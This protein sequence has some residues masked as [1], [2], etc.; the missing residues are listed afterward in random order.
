[1][2]ATFELCNSYVFEKN[3]GE[4]GK[5]AD[6]STR[7]EEMVV[8]LPVTLKTHCG[9]VR[10]VMTAAAGPKSRYSDGGVTSTN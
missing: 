9:D 1:M 6:I 5:D 7:M 8:L 3:K 4:S 10:T 2:K